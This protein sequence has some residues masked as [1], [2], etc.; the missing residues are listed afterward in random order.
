MVEPAI[1][2]G[3]TFFYRLF[4]HEPV[5]TS[6][7]P[8]ESGA[9]NPGRD[10]NDANQAVPTLIATKYRDRVHSQFPGLQ[11][12]QVD[13]FSLATYPMSGGFKPWSLISTGTAR[14]LLRI[15]R[16]I[17]PIIGRYLG[18]RVMITIEKR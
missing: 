18:F 2:F 7:D 13:W 10:P 14:R 4:H 6:A 1:T 17:E 16:V 9:R 3:S 11:I 12:S 5:V 8:L 15:E